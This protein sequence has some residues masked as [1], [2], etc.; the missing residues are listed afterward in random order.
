MSR[1][2]IIGS[3]PAGATAVEMLATDPTQQIDVLD[4]GV[5][6]EP[7]RAALLELVKQLP[8]RSWPASATTLTEQPRHIGSMLPEKRVL[9]SDYPFRNEGQLDGMVQEGASNEHVTSGAL[10]GFSNVW[11]AQIFP[12]PRE[13]TSGWP[14]DGAELR[15]AYR[16]VLRLIPYAAVEDDFA[17]IFPLLGEPAGLPVLSPRTVRTMDRYAKH[18]ARVRRLGV[19]LGHA[20][21]AF[22]SAECHPCNLCMTGCP[23]DLIF[24][25]RH[26][27]KPRIRSGRVRYFDKTM[28]VRLS[29]SATGATVHVKNLRTGTLDRLEY[30]RVFVACGAIA[31]TRLAV[32]LRP[33]PSYTLPLQEAAQFL[34]PMLSA[35]ST[36]DPRDYDAFTLNQ[37]NALVSTP[38]LHGDV[39]FIHFYPFNSAML[40]ALPTI[41]GNGRRLSGALLARLSVG[42]GYLPSGASPSQTIEVRAHSD[43]GRLPDAVIRRQPGGLYREHLRAVWASLARVA[44]LL[45]LWPMPYMPIAAAGKTYHFGSTLAHSMAPRAGTLQTDTLGRLAGSRRIHFVDGSTLP[46]I[47]ATTFTLTV[48]ANAARIAKSTLGIESVQ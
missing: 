33:Q 22:R 16:D 24:S 44:P 15:T 45:D 9:G 37:F 1:V 48:M 28:A 4:I 13:T 41:F 14:I 11:G 36:S 26:L 20:R 25:A 3:G 8:P 2:A 39:A 5:T 43:Q 6:L 29:E 35:A 7:E 46:S 27:L 38:T 21:L 47:P 34:I 40:G 32:S 10:G 12:F 18:R 42:L 19:T 31:S 23:N 30:D 17:E